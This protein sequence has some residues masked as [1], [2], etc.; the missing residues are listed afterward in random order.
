MAGTITDQIILKRKHINLTGEDKYGHW[1]TELRDGA[2]KPVESYGWWPKG[3]V[4]PKETLLGT[5]GELN[6]VTN[7]GGSATKDPHHGDGAEEAF[8]VEIPA[9]KTVDDA[10]QDV[11][12]FANGYSGEWRWTFG[13]GQN[14]H[15]FQESLISAAGFVKKPLGSAAGGS[16]GA[17]KAA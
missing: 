11:R 10:K 4:G 16:S 2:K 14:C 5:E 3:P 8:E 7:F 1:W 17:K 6:G 12:T 9:G 15:T 13:Y